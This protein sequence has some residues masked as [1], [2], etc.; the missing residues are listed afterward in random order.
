MN[1]VLRPSSKMKRSEGSLSLR[2]IQYRGVKTVTLPGCKLYEEE[3]DKIKQEIVYPENDPLR[4]LHLKKTEAKISQEMELIHYYL[5]SLEKQGRYSV[6]DLVKL[7]RRKKD[8]GKLLGYTEI[9]IQEKEESGQIRTARA[10]RTVTCGLV[11]FNKGEDIPLSQ[12]NARLIKDFEIYLKELGRMPNTVSYYMRILRAIYNKAV[13]DKRIINRNGENPFA[14]VSTGV[15]KT[16][17]RALSLNEMQA[18]H[19]ID[20]KQLQKKEEVQSQKH[21]QLESLHMA[22]RLFKFCF[23]CRG[24]CFVD[25]SY[26]RKDNIRGGVIRY[27]RKKTGTYMEIRVTSLMQQIIDSFA[28]ETRD[29]LY[30]FPIIKEAGKDSRLQYESALRVQNDRL[31]RL[32]LFAGIDKPVSTHM[33]RHTWATIAKEKNI[34]LPVISESLGHSSERTTQIYLGLLENSLLD[35]VNDEIAAAVAKT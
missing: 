12:I 13:L 19:E 10:Y 21:V 16:M 30:V 33:S 14:D 29:S 5:A 24:M 1:L 23:F 6:E 4:V 31:K 26:L 18:I 28:E 34:P 8:D 15:Y 3:W 35:T 20:F 17:K 9:L 11:K 27:T 25:L 32:A 7:Y 2:L 22:Q